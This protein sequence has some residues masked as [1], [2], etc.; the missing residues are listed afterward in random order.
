MQQLNGIQLLAV[1]AMPVLFAITVHE[2]AHGYIARLLGDDTATRMGRLSLNPL[3]HIDPI[4]T[5]LVPILLMFA[6]GFIFGWAKPVPIDPRRLRRPKQDMAWVAIA[7]PISNLMMAVGWAVLLRLNPF[8]TVIPGAG[9]YLVYVCSAGITINAVLLALNL[10]PIPPLDGGR[11]MVG[12]LPLPA[13]RIL[14]QVEPFGLVIII[15]LLMTG[16]FAQFLIPAVNLLRTI[17]LSM[18]GVSL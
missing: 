7:G 13:A 16:L 4:G 15:V 3:R 9:E 10:L 12:I 2:Y 6:G 11:V 18:V 17:L 1:W 14:A 5:L 8:F